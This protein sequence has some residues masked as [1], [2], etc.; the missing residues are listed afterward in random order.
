MV[1]TAHLM[2]RRIAGADGAGVIPVEHPLPRRV[3]HE[4]RDPDAAIAGVVARRFGKARARIDG[5]GLGQAVR[6]NRAI[7]ELRAAG[8]TI[9]T[10]QVRNRLAR[11]GGC[12]S[13][14]ETPSGAGGIAIPGRH[15]ILRG[16][17]T[18][19]RPDGVVVRLLR[20]DGGSLGFAIFVSEN[21]AP[22]LYCRG[23]RGSA[24]SAARPSG[25]P[26]LAGAPRSELNQ[27]QEQIIALVRERGFVAIEA[28][29]DHFDVTPQ[30]IRRDI[31]QLCDLGLLRRY[32]GG[33][34]LP[35]SVE[36]LAYQTRQVLQDRKS[37]V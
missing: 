19:R 15:R 6:P 14:Y 32:H 26:D 18:F 31:N 35:S 11:P 33:A 27:R 28:L 12:R 13:G 20:Q 29:A 25:A 5:E 9:L 3:R 23:R 4:R 7:L 37:V 1:G 21:Q 22:D 16:H 24:M 8:G 2:L 30:T 34:G 17:R 36:N 10:P